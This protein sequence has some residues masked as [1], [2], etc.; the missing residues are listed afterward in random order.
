ML[1]GSRAP[2]RSRSPPPP[3]PPRP[4]PRSAPRPS[5][6]RRPSSPCGATSTPTPSSATARSAR[7]TWWPS[8]CATSASRCATRW[9][10]RGSWASCAAGAPG[11][12]SRCAP[13]STP[14]RSRR[15]ATCRSGARRRASCTRAATTPTPRSCSARP[16]CSPACRARLPGTVVFLFQPAEEG[17]P[18]GEEGGAPLMVKEGALDDPKVEAVFG[19][20]VGS[21]VA[22]RARPGWTDGPIFASSDT[23]TI[24]V[25]GKTVHGAQ[26]HMGLDPIPVAA[27]IVMALQ[28]DRLAPD[29]RP[30]APRPHDR[31]HPG[32]HPLQHHR[33][34]A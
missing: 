1:G 16:R 28:L 27:E 9:R 13:T 19:L 8:G 26:P 34:P 4:T 22:G 21:W 32:R 14:C 6:S 3:R 11:G 17:A 2:R 33:G 29:R 31:A 10:R 25:E 18:E 24:E 23:F 12:W 30:A 15:R 20:H 7:A 5:G